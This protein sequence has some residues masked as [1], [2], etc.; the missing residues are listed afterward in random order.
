MRR[1]ASK[2]VLAKYETDENALI[3]DNIKKYTDKTGR[4][5]SRAYKLATKNINK[6]VLD[7][8]P[9]TMKQIYQDGMANTYLE[10]YRDIRKNKV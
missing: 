4:I 9:D 8:E 5:R 1:E 3:Q 7:W 6:Q 10:R 2:D